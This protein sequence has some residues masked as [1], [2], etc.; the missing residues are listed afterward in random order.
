MS[1]DMPWLPRPK[2][3]FALPLPCVFHMSGF[4]EKYVAQ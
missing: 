3:S 4:R 1:W 2:P